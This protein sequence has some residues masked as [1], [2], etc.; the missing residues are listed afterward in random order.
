MNYKLKFK[1]SA[2]KEWHKCD[3][4]IKQQFKKQIN[5]ILVNP[6]IPIKRLSGFGDRHIYKIKL[7]NLGYRLIYEVCDNDVVITIITVG[8]RDKIYSNIN[9]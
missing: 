7:Q 4:N 9:S 6:H 8:R 3:N 1:Q 2:L 5:K